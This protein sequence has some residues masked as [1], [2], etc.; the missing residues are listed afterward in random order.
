MNEHVIM[1]I[2]QDDGSFELVC[3]PLGK[4]APSRRI[5]CVRRLAGSSSSTAIS[6]ATSIP[7]W[8]SMSRFSTSPTR[9]SASSC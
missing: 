2:V 9:T 1:G 6:A 7:T 8:K 4:G 5:R 3:G